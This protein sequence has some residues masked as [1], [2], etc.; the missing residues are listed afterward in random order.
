[1]HPERK[2]LCLAQQGEVFLNKGAYNKDTYMLKGNRREKGRSQRWVSAMVGVSLALMAQAQTVQLN[3]QMETLFRVAEEH[4]ADIRSYRTAVEEAQ[5]AHRTAETQRLPDVEAQVS[6][7]YLGDGR[8]WNRHF[9]EGMKIPMPHWG[10][11]YVLRAQQ[12][13]YAGGAINSSIRL[14]ELAAE[15]ATLSAEENRQR[16]RMLLVGLYLQLHSLE[17]RTEVLNNNLALADTLIAHMEHRRTQGVVLQNDITRSELQREQFMLNKIRVTDERSIAQ[18][19]LA[20]AI[21]TD[22][23]LSLLPKAVFDEAAWVLNGEVY[24]QQASVAHAG[25]KQAA[26]SIDMRRQEERIERAARRPK[27]ALVAEDHLTGPVT[28]EV[29]TLNKNFNYWFVGVGVSYNFSSLY[30]SNRKVHRAQVATR[31]AM[32]RHEAARQ[33]VS[34]GIHAAY[35]ACQTAQSELQTHRKRVQLAVQNYDVVR[36]RYENGLALITD[37]TDAANM[38]LDAELALANAQINLAYHYYALRFAAGVL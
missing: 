10:N 25:L 32:D 23:L 2:I 5:A 33:K 27:V 7:S 21:G 28:I 17:H 11:D 24:W 14:S 20:T 38:K 26:L 30:K 34:D 19:Q 13:I 12:V 31:H 37:M 29:P 6:F 1:M 3:T 9:G 18:R 15:M 36:R 16:V 4:N 8:L 35:V 22:T